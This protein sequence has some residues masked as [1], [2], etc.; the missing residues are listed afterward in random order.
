MIIIFLDKNLVL[1][2]KFE[3]SFEDLSLSR[4]EN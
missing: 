1:Y 3:N 4:I 2:Y